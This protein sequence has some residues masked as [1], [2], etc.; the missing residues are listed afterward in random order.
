MTLSREKCQLRQTEFTYLGE[1]PTQHGVKPDGDK[2]KAIRDYVKPTNKQDV[3]RLLGMVNFIAKFA[4]KVSDVTAPLR[5]L[6]KK[7]IAFTG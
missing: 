2:L 3:P 7:N 1:I 6:F 4:P 5:E